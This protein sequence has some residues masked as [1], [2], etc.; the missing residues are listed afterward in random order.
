M[1]NAKALEEKLAHRKDIWYAQYAAGEAICMVASSL[2][3]G[4]IQFILFE[5]PICLRV[6]ISI[7][8][9]PAAERWSACV[10]QSLLCGALSSRVLTVHT[11]VEVPRDC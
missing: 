1:H 11:H 6:C 2:H 10:Q 7:G 4:S 9:I 5:L 3:G 8:D